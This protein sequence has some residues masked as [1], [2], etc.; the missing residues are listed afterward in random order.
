M[1]L[2]SSEDGFTSTDVSVSDPSVTENSVHVKDVG[3][4][5]KSM[6]VNETLAPS[7]VNTTDSLTRFPTVFLCVSISDS[8]WTES[9]SDVNDACDASLLWEESER[10]MI[11]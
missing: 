4:M 10:R 3:V 7:I 9:V 6:R 1:V 5:E 2:M 11:E 8:G